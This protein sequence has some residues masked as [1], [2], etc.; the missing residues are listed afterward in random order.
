MIHKDGE[1]ILIE[2]DI[3]VDTSS[4]LV[5]LSIAHYKIQLLNF[6]MYLVNYI[7]DLLV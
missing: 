2:Y 3:R 1:R 7:V 4:T 6:R 5:C